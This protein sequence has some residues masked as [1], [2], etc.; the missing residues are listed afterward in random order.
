[1]SSSVHIFSFH[2]S[3]GFYF[4]IV[5]YNRTWCSGDYL[6]GNGNEKLF[7]N[8]VSIYF[9]AYKIVLN[10][11]T[12]W[13]LRYAWDIYV[14]IYN[15]FGGKIQSRVLISE[16]K[17][18]KCWNGIFKWS[19]LYIFIS[20]SLQNQTHRVRSLSSASWLDFTKFNLCIHIG[21]YFVLCYIIFF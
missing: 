3:S 12:L 17:Y 2:L 7:W 5:S 9:K 15:L 21:Y 10:C 8:T 14:Y 13:M 11:N 16:R 20:Q 4:T 19:L 18:F 1:M 6:R